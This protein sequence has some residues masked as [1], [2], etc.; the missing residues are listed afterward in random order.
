M[1]Y[2]KHSVGFIIFIISLLLFFFYIQCGCPEEAS[3]LV[4][5]SIKPSPFVSEEINT[6]PPK[7][8]GLAEGVSESS[9]SYMDMAIIG[10]FFTNVCL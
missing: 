2:N 4:Q 6:I 9:Y 3:S 5:E 7:E 10:L 8:E 1:F